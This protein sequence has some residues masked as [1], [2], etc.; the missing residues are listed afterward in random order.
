MFKKKIFDSMRGGYRNFQPSATA[1]ETMKEKSASTPKVRRLLAYFA[2]YRRSLPELGH[3]LPTIQTPTLIT[4]G[5]EDPLVKHSI[6]EY[7]HERMPNSAID[8]IDGA[9]HEATQDGGQAYLDTV[10]NWFS[11][12][13][14]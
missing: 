10:H 2:A 4:W 11:T 13:R 3:A 7:V 6:A 8:I 14:P 9:G 5:K 12:H 1:V